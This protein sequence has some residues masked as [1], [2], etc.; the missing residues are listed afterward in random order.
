M[1]KPQHIAIIGGGLAGTFQAARLLDA[2]FAVTLFDQATP[3]TAS[4]VAAGMFNIITGRFGA[5]SWRGEQ[6]LS[7]ISA[8]LKLPQYRSLQEF[9]HYT[10][11]YRPFRDAAEYNKWTGRREEAGFAHLVRFHE[12]PLYPEQLINPLG[13]IMI[14]PC[15]WMETDRFLDAFHPLLA[16]RPGFRLVNQHLSYGQIDLGPQLIR[17]GEEKI[18]F[19]HL[20]FAEGPQATDNP[21]FPTVR[22]IPNKGE[23]LVLEIPE[24][25]LPFVLSKKVYLLPIGEQRFVCGSNYQNRFDHPHPTEAGKA[26]IL[27]HLEKVLRLPYRLLEHK[28]GI[29]PTTPN[30]RPV[31]GTHPELT[32]VHILSGYGTKGVLLA[33]YTSRLLTEQILGLNPEIPPEAGVERFG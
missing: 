26:E 9:V 25:E 33:P 8:F 5:K 1:N 31:L 3:H 13:G 4:R 21:W 14:L 7:E 11:I 30:R 24:L 29:R 15:G 23:I 2:G 12:E 19:D 6:L 10:E 22:I 16:E 28:A 27:G 17:L 18:A 32:Y 20:V